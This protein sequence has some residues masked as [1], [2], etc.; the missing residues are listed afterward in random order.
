MPTTPD[1]SLLASAVETVQQNL[2]SATTKAEEP[3]LAAGQATLRA[4]LPIAEQGIPLRKA[5]LDAPV[6][7]R[8]EQNEVFPTWP[9][10]PTLRA[11]ANAQRLSADIPDVI[12][13]PFRR[14]R[15]TVNGFCDEIPRAEAA[16]NAIPKLSLKDVERP[17]QWRNT[18]FWPAMGGVARLR[19]DLCNMGMGR[20]RLD[21]AARALA[22]SLEALLRWSRG[23]KERGVREAAMTRQPDPEANTETVLSIKPFRGMAHGHD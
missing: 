14:S 18:P 13:E 4:C 20:D 10:I 9:D 23:Q 5:W 11:A 15:E 16:V 12:A 2:S 22:A 17:P 8:P 1:K 21:D 7:P 19:Q 6:V 3:E